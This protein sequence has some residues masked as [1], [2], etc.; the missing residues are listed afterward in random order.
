MVEVAE[1][2]GGKD[3]MT[4]IKV[5]TKTAGKLLLICRQLDKE[6]RALDSTK[7]NLL[8]MVRYG[9]WGPTLKDVY[10]KLEV[11]K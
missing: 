3:R 1:G 9:K 7:G 8:E 4:S 10:K 2:E 5:D 6:T 11:T